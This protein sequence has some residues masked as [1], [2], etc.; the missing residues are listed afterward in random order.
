MTNE[1]ML[2]LVKDV[3]TAHGAGDAHDGYD[4]PELTLIGDA[5]TIILGLPGGGFDGPYGMTEPEFE[6]M[7]DR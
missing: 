5:S 1:S 7:V 4:A 6:F 3:M 2:A